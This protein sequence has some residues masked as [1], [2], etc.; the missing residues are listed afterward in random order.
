MRGYGDFFMPKTVFYNGKFY[1]S[2]V[3]VVP[4]S[5][6]SIFFG[7]AVYDAMVGR[8]GGIFLIDEHLERLFS[9]ARRI[10]IG[11]NYSIAQLSAILYNV[12]KKSKLEEYFLYIQLSRCSAERVILS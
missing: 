4:L 9:T 5:D 12:V 8:C 7:D 2:G 6:R 10:G 1:R 11:C 3:G